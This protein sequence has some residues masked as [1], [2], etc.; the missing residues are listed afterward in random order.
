MLRRVFT[1]CSLLVLV[2]CAGGPQL[3]VVSQAEPNPLKGQGELALAALDFSDFQVGKF[4]SE[5][6]FLE[7]KKKESDKSAWEEDK[8]T[9]ERSL[10]RTLTEGALAKGLKVTPGETAPFIIRAKVTYV[11][12]GSLNRDTEV[13]LTVKIASSDGKNVDELHTI[14]SIGPVLGSST[15]S[16]F[17]YVG[18]KLGKSLAEYLLK[19]TGR[20]E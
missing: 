15:G 4:K 14:G 5:A 9:L 3:T 11:D 10:E 16:R 19:R 7:K 8:G 20:S 18:E 6:D 2:A 1:V 17:K 12:P 13:N